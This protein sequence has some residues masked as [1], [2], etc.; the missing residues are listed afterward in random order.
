MG[1]ILGGG[2]NNKFLLHYHSPNENRLYFFDP[3]RET[4]H[5]LPVFYKGKPF[6]FG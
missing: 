5:C 2:S 4:F 1:G 3:K 6:F